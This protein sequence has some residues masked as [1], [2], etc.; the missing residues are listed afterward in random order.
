MTNKTYSGNNIQELISSDECLKIHIKI[1]KEAQILIFFV[2]YRNT[3]IYGAPFSVQRK[4][5]QFIFHCKPENFKNYDNFFYQAY[6]MK[7]QFVFKLFLI[8]M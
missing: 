5:F 2:G 3:E 1:K 6:N 4:S 8:D 7:K